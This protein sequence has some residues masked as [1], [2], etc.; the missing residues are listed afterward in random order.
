M[1]AVP[2]DRLLVEFETVAI[3]RGPKPVRF[4]EHD[5]ATSGRRPD[6]LAAEIDAAYA[7]GLA[8]G[9]QFAEQ[10]AAAAQMAAVELQARAFAERT[11]QTAAR[12]IAHVDH[13]LGAMHLE[14]TQ[15]MARLLEPLLANWIR[16]D[17]LE[18]LAARLATVLHD[19]VGLDIR[20]EGPDDLV[21]PLSR[22]VATQGKDHCVTIR[23]SEATDVRVTVDQ[24]L[25]ET[26]IGA[27]LQAIEA[28]R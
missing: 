4:R 5:G 12:I 16:A 17:A 8:A 19:K 11:E 20:I 24:L 7:R 28:S 21:T 27:W 26:Q 10:Q 14:V 18:T 2:A 13:Q 3:A 23:R 9:H 25:L 6:A 1:S 22:V 15:T